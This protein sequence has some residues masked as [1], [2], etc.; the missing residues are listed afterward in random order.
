MVWAVACLFLLQAL[1][2]IFS[3]NGRV[4]FSS[5]GAGASIA[6]AGEICHAKAD[7]D[8][9]APAHSDHHSH[10]D[11]CSIGNHDQVASAVAIL[12]RVIAVL[13]PRSDEAPAWFVFKEPTL[14]SDAS[15]SSWSSR[16]PP[17]FS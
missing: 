5:A 3:A 9:K 1:A 4:A 15:V 11:V 6:M 7:D 16:A 2:F 10:C 14:A 13:V 17:L 12:P 8:D